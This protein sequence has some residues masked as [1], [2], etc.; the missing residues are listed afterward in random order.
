MRKI[1]GALLKTQI[2]TKI[3]EDKS[4]LL[5]LQIH[6]ND[7][8]KVK[9]SPVAILVSI[10]GVQPS[11]DFVDASNNL[12]RVSSQPGVQIIR[13]IFPAP[14]VHP[15]KQ[16]VGKSYTGLMLLIRVTLK[17]HVRSEKALSVI[18]RE[19][20]KEFTKRRSMTYT[21]LEASGC[22]VTLITGKKLLKVHLH[23]EKIS[24]GIS[25]FR[26]SKGFHSKLI[27]PFLKLDRVP[28]RII[29]DYP[30]QNLPVV[31]KIGVRIDNPSQ[32]VGLP[33]LNSGTVLACGYSNN[34]IISVLQN[35]IISFTKTI[36]E[37]QIFVIDTRNEMNGV[38]KYFQENP[39]GLGDLNLQV[40]R[41][42]TN[43]HLNLCEVIIPLS[44]GGKKVDLK[45]QASWKSHIIKQILLSSLITSDYLSERFSIPLEAHIKKTAEVNFNFTLN[46][47]QLN[48]GGASAGDPKVSTEGVDMMFADMMAIDALVGILDQFRSFP[49]VCYSGFTGHF[50]EA[51]TR[52]K[53]LTF[54]QFGAQPPIIRRATVA[55]LL[56]YLSELKNGCIVLTH[57]EEYISRKTAYG[58]SRTTI[59]SSLVEACNNISKNNVL[60]LGTQSLTALSVNMDSF[61]E[62]KNSIY[63]KMVS[64]DDRNIVKSLHELLPDKYSREPFL[65][66][67]EK[68]G[69]LFREDIPQNVGFHFKID[70]PAIPI[71]LQPVYVKEAKQRGSET[72]GLT[73]TKFEL[74]MKALK[75]LISRPC[76]K[77]EVISLIE[78]NKHGEMSLDQFLPL[79]LWDTKAEAGATYWA[80]NET[81]RDYYSKQ[82][83]NLAKLPTPLSTKEL[84]V[85]L[86]ELNR[87]ES[88]YDISS[89]KSDRLDTNTK[90]K[91]LIGRLLNHLRVLKVTSIPWS[92]IAEYYDLTQI[93][94][95]EWQDFRNLFELADS[96]C[97]NLIL[98]IT[99]HY[100]ESNQQENQHAIQASSIKSTQ[101]EKVLD[102]YLP[103]NYFS[104]LQK[105]SRELDFE[106]YPTTGI[107][108]IFF[109]L[110]TKQRSL[111]DEIDK[112]RRNK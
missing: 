3:L 73:P 14:L 93:E 110:H 1:T 38:I 59:P 86:D 72:L 94:S 54:F 71:D 49:E 5:Q 10:F 107:L 51:L 101:A 77:D 69:L 102:D 23:G 92:R 35:L 2:A 112:S 89:S 100:T 98:E 78:K 32:P 45:V 103:N 50:S 6:E 42:G 87:L 24:E 22:N 13:Q 27:Q 18:L 40:F 99:Q 63:L 52:E 104:I 47:V 43:F 111:F 56:H 85:S 58:R 88:F 66:I 79:G 91:T 26:G 75:L 108:D 67:S 21:L 16:Q 33:N 60:L 76:P 9:T 7:T 25:V 39:S 34:D 53:T 15:K 8:N 36:S 96:M 41:L 80:I 74:L 68:E 64:L 37:N 48:V 95:L 4:T 46:D 30:A 17:F 55:F 29:Y 106:T 90:V 57:S 31:H 105:I 70:S 44:P 83:E 19:A 97:N 109:E 11:K 65:G 12:F 62:I 61:E 28:S 84:E 81:G 82:Y 20:R